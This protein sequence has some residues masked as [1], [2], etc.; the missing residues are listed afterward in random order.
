MS[1]TSPEIWRGVEELQAGEEAFVVW[2]LKG[3]PDTER[4]NQLPTFGDISLKS[5]VP[6]SQ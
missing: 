5:N 6:N 3:C 2:T 1:K 4:Q